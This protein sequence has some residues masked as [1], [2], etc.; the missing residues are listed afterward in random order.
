MQPGVLTNLG[1]V[2]AEDMGPNQNSF[3]LDDVE[4]ATGLSKQ[5]ILSGPNWTPS[6]PLPLGLADVEQIARAQLRTI[7]QDEPSW[8]VLDISLLRLSE[9]NLQGSP[10]WQYTV[11]LGPR[12]DLSPITSAGHINTFTA[13]VSMSGEV[14]SV[15]LRGAQ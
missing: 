10:K 5:S 8:V 13:H 1:P 15:G 2:S 4:L 14:G 12:P 6:E 11:M 9:P 7:V 3:F